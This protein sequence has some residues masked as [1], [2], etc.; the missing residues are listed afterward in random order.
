MAAASQLEQISKLVERLKPLLGKQRGMPIDADDWNLLVG[1]MIDALEIDRVQEQGGPAALDERFARREHEHPGQVTLDWLDAE[2]QSRVATGGGSLGTRVALGE[3]QKL[4]DSLG[5]ETARLTSVAEDQQRRLDRA[6]GEELARAAQLRS[7]NDRF[8]TI[9][10]LRPTIDE[11][12]AHVDGVNSRLGEVLEFR[13]QLTDAGGQPIDVAALAKEQGALRKLSENFNGVDGNPVRMRDLEVRITELED[14]INPDTAGRLEARIAAAVA[15][16]EERLAK[17]QD[18]HDA[19]LAGKL[20]QELADTR[21]QLQA[22][23]D[24]RL[25][26]LDERVAKLF[27]EIQGKLP[28]LVKDAIGGAL[29]ELREE[30][31]GQLEQFR[32]EILKLLRDLQ[33]KYE[34]R[35]RRIEERLQIPPD[36]RFP[37][38]IRIPPDVL[39]RP[40]RPVDG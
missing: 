32:E 16:A 5:T 8:A 23:L 28:E 12:G 21:A 40:D 31:K 2:L 10:G 7:F 13:E 14:S 24:G 4:V 37:T 34:A 18:E 22:T 29:D 39:I 11:L 36:P 20:E 1:S 17:R 33:T 38:D 9:E 26:E 35:F 30:V 6:S 15:A 25:A 27:D 3:T 19:A